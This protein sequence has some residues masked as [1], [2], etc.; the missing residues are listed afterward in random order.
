MSHS[1][2]NRCPPWEKSRFSGHSPIIRI[3]PQSGHPDKPVAAIEKR[4]SFP[5]PGRHAFF[6]ESMLEALGRTLRMET[7][8]F[9]AA[10]SPDIDLE[11]LFR[12]QPFLAFF[13]MKDAAE[14]GNGHR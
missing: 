4:N 8:M 13:E 14:L 7:E 10:P 12:I 2:S 3:R 11:K 5:L 9:P 6:L 1:G